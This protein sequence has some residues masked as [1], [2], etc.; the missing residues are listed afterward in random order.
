METTVIS[1]VLLAATAAILAAILYQYHKFNADTDWYRN[2]VIDLADD[3]NK[4]TQ[5]IKAVT[6]DLYERKKIR[7]KLYND[8]E[9]YLPI[10]AS[11]GDWID[12]KARGTHELKKG[13]YKLIPLGVAMELPR[14]FEAIVAPR[15][16]IT[17]NFRVM[18]S[19]SIGVIDNAYNGDGDEWGAYVYAVADTVIHD[20]ERI[21][22][23]R[24]Q[25]NQPHIDFLQV[26]SLGNEN[27]GGFGSTGK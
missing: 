17:K 3:T 13:E 24:I 6:S 10:Q 4:L 12:L 8:S 7:V 9:T 21:V 27:R 15:S 26:K 14:G 11:K 19:N 18:Q 20:G 2:K 25:M 23:F 1:G 5:V 22:Q 16:S